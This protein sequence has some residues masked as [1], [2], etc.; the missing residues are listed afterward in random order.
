MGQLTAQA[1]LFWVPL[2][3]PHFFEKLKWMLRKDFFSVTVVV[4]G[5][6]L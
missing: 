4:V 2:L 3:S 5:V 6:V 1:L